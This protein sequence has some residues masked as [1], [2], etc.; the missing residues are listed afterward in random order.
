MSN[1]DIISSVVS[2]KEMFESNTSFDSNTYNKPSETFIEVFKVSVNTYKNSH[3]TDYIKKYEEPTF[4]HRTRDKFLKELTELCDDWCVYVEEDL[5]ISRDLTLSDGI[6][7]KDE[8][9]QDD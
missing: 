6:L 7:E 2:S 8:E 1:T 5:G 3:I 9:E 4:N